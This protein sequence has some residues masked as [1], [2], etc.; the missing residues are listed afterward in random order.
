MLLTL[1]SLVSELHY[2]PYS[3]YWWLISNEDQTILLIRLGQKG[4]VCLNNNDFFITIQTGS[5]NT[6]LLPAYCCQ[7]GIYTATETS[8]TK[9][10]FNVYRQ[11]FNT[12]TRYLGYQIMG[13]NDNNIIEKLKEDIQ[14]IPFNIKLGSNNIFIYSIGISSYEKWYY[15]VWEKTEQLR[16]FTGKQLFGLDNSI[17]KNLIQ[18]YSTT[19]YTPNDWDNED[20]LKQLFNYHL[21]RRTILVFLYITNTLSRSSLDTGLQI[22][23]EMTE[24]EL[25]KISL[26]GFGSLGGRL[27]CYGK[28]SR[29][30]S[31]KFFVKRCGSLDR[32]ILLVINT[33]LQ[34]IKL[35][36]FTSF[37][38][39]EIS[40]WFF[41]NF[42]QMWEI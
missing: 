16:K 4:K 26:C 24:I 29:A 27:R 38:A 15:A 10:I 41:Q 7:S 2:G 23:C 1:G 18:Q 17:T 35:T 20:I 32:N 11:C 40:P 33:I 34:N 36:L 8:P 5:E 42:R 9:A 19:K 12:C 13:W 22:A 28:C 37:G 3:F 39:L 21:K 14:F 30:K 6:A 31:L 25:K